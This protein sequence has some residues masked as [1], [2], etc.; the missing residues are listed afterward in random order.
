MNESL[1]MPADKSSGWNPPEETPLHAK[2]RESAGRFLLL[3][4]AVGGAFALLF[5][6]AELGLN[7]PVFTAVFLLCLAA[8]LKKLG[9][10]DAKKFLPGA[11]AMALLALSAFLTAN[12]FVQGV[13]CLGLAILA[14]MLVLRH[15]CATG[16]WQLGK[17]VSAVLRLVWSALLSLPEPVRALFGLRQKRAGGRGK[18][19]VIGL[20]VSVPLV[21]VVLPLLLSADAVFADLLR[22]AFSLDISLPRA[23]Q[24]ALEALC[25][26]LC[27][28]LGFYS[29]LAGQSRAPVP[30]E[31][32]LR[33][34]R[35]PLVAV[36]FTAVLL[37][38]YALFCL[39]QIVVLFA[40]G[41]TLPDGM[42]YAEYA[43]QG[44]FQLL[45][46]AA[47]NAAL[48]AFCSRRFGEN[49]A[50]RALLTAVC[51]CTYILIASSAY[52][53]LLYVGA[54]GLTFLRILVL[55][56]LG[57]LAILLSGIAVSLYRGKF[58][59]FRFVF[60]VCLAGWLVFSFSKPD[61]LAAQYNVSAFG[62][63]DGIGYSMMYELSMDA[64][65]VM[66]RAE[67]GGEHPGVWDSYLH[68]DVPQ[69]AAGR[70]LRDFDLALWDAARAVA[71]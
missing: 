2:L 57:V 16:R 38:I 53:M 10:W 64:V 48:V 63:T 70:G 24:T 22:R 45:F 35:E 20:C 34:P 37:A 9:L 42:T 17:Y 71:P 29:A 54:Y 32:K 55:W 26:F 21:F 68:R 30:S 47:L 46:V 56:F 31:T 3:A 12:S 40:G 51:V 28:S 6:R 44:F 14:A 15:F 59:L 58:D 67:Y 11:A 19:V 69:A 41:G 52:R 13:D 60:A 25:L 4:G 49:R 61:R 8:A 50:L 39:V 5:T 7:V 23:L 43:R 36:T 65:P 1:P 66:A 18:Y 33:K 27:A 62:V